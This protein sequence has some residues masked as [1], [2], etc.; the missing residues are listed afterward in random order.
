MLLTLFVFLVLLSILVLIHELGHFLVAKKLNIK[1]EE[2]GFGLPPRLW[3]IKKGETIYSINWLPIGGF[4]K[5]FGEDDAGKGDISG[6]KY[7]VA[8]IKKDKKIHDTKYKLHNTDLKRAFFA[9][10]VWQRA[11]VVGAGV[12]MNCLLAIV[13]FY[14]YMFVSG[15]R[16]ELPLLSPYHFIGVTQTTKEQIL[17]SAVAK[18]SPASQAGLPVGVEITKLN[19]QQ[20]TSLTTFIADIKADAGKKVVLTLVDPASQKSSTKTITP[21]SNPPKGQGALGV[22]LYDMSTA[23]LDY[24]TPTQKILS[25]V[26]HPINLLFYNLDLIG[27]LIHSAIKTHDA[28]ALGE[29]VSGPVGIYSV[30]GAIVQIPNLKEQTLQLLNLAGL[31]SISLAFF[32]VL[33]IPALDGGRLFF[34]LIEGITRKKVN[35]RFET[36]AHTIGMGVLLL[37]ILLITFKDIL[38][39]IIH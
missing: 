10:P 26:I 19:G 15:F 18:N 6:I 35:P 29:G 11:A 13:I 5:L 12:I 4:V 31:L 39:F 34:I 38:Q 24:Q 27:Q 3:G 30:V 8:S 36:M 1:V 37:L 25:G 16:A 17:V 33:P 20:I 28:T 7:Q 21:R 23:V 14:T 9:R 2:F 32:N 22:G